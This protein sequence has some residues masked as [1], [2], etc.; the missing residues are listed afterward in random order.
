MNTYR[1]RV[2]LTGTPGQRTSSSAGCIVMRR[3]VA[4]P[5]PR[6]RCV[7]TASPSLQ[8]IW[9]FNIGLPDLWLYSPSTRRIRL[10]EIKSPSDSLAPHQREWQRNLTLCG[11]D[12]CVG[13]VRHHMSDPK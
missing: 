10:V 4:A 11:I 2:V 6:E 12:T 7:A 3:G 1:L 13:H 8:R 9:D 5:L